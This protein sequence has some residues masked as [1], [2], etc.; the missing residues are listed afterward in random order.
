MRSASEND[1]PTPSST[2]PSINWPDEEY[3]QRSSN[4]LHH[5]E[6]QTG[7]SV[8]RKRKEYLVLTDTHI[9]RFKSQQ[10]ASET[11]NIIPPMKAPIKRHSYNLST[12]SA[13]D[14]LSS[15]EPFEERA[16]G[17]PL[18]NVVAVY[19]LDDG[20]PCFALQIDCLNERTN[21][22]SSVLLQFSEPDERDT[23]LYAI[24]QAAHEGTLIDGEP[25]SQFNTALV[26]RSV[27]RDGDYQPD[28]F[29]IYK[30][31]QRLS[32][33]VGDRSSSEDLTKSG[34]T[35]CFLVIG[36]YKI[37]IIPLYK[38]QNSSSS[39][40]LGSLATHESFGILAITCLR[41]CPSDDNFEITYRL[42]FQRSKVL[43]LA[44]VSSSDFV[45][46]FRFAEDVLRPE[47]E[48]RPYQFIV[49]KTFEESVH[50]LT[51]SAA[52]APETFERTLAGYCKAYGVSVGDISYQFSYPYE[53]A[54]CF[55]LLPPPGNSR[56]DYSSLELLAVLRALRYHESFISL[57]FANVSLDNLGG[58]RDHHGNEHI[59]SKTK[60]GSVIEVDTQ[61]LTRARLLVQ[62]IRALAITN[63]R[64]RRVDFSFCISRIPPDSF[65]ERRHSDPGCGIA[66]ALYLLFQHQM[67]NIDWIILNGIRMGE[68][69]MGYLIESASNPRCHFRALELSDCGISD[70]DFAQLFGALRNAHSSTLEAINLSKNPLRLDPYTFGA[71]VESFENLR[72]LCLA[73]LV[74]ESSPSPL[75]DPH[76]LRSWRLE[77]LH[78][79]GTTINSA[80]VE[81]I[82]IYLA[83]TQS[84]LLREL[85][86]DSTRISGRDIA[87]LLS[88]MTTEPGKGREI[89]LDVSRNRFET[90]FHELV[91]AVRR[92]YAPAYLT[93]RYMEFEE[94]SYFRR[95]IDAF[96]GNTTITHLDISRPSLPGSASEETIDSLEALLSR[97]IV[98]ESLDISGEDAKLEA[99]HL[100]PGLNR[101]LVGLK[102]N[103]SLRTLCVHFQRLGHR[104]ADTIAD[105]I[106]HNT[107]LQQLYCD[108][109]E[110]P[111]S[112]FT[113]IVNALEENT[114]LLVL[115]TMD[116]SREEGIK[117]TIKEATEVQGVG[118][119]QPEQQSSSMRTRIVSRVV[120]PKPRRP[121]NA[122]PI[123]LTQQDIQAAVGLL[124]HGWDFQVSRLQQYL[125]RNY[126]ITNG[127][128]LED[129][130]PDQ[131]Y[132]NDVIE[133]IQ[134]SAMAANVTE[135]LEKVKTD[136]TPRVEKQLNFDGATMN[137][138]DGPPSLMD[139][140]EMVL[141]KSPSIGSRADDLRLVLPKKVREKRDSKDDSQH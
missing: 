137:L 91:S 120:S 98:L 50:G 86:L 134:V 92:G 114:T 85:R 119:P 75:L 79:S 3:V 83:S 28:A 45:R 37:H 99:I 132:T 126:R 59:C 8:F 74:L 14:V 108:N 29:T 65:D 57:S 4:V 68:T 47:W 46:Q 127:L 104:G 12:G 102:Q 61:E 9:M 77:E 7:A 129:I 24:R 16:V 118:S 63:Q 80:T 73:N 70:R 139:E 112:G 89:H 54:P 43:Y 49:P 140:I 40:S 94:E 138:P 103:N 18:R 87:T 93:I 95:L 60:R 128:P 100:G 56:T 123:T 88:C 5:G 117:Q 106:R 90:G 96:A 109:N 44:S 26:A 110:I 19:V 38:F 69:D 135:L 52:M 72:K 116:E 55:E 32:P 36:P 97:N 10:K 124:H 62:E 27:E 82:G 51:P 81:S 53:D 67:T 141:E 33:K 13:N 136:S 115:P 101:A 78:L 31:V 76:I 41:L 39:P 42:P 84:K 1:V 23:W 130:I 34:S 64:L 22:A 122:L 133:D 35:V 121:S 15:L 125:E 107:S 2:T 21:Q 58:I 25:I 131:G 30:V 17:T 71:Q 11:F 66:E 6:A 111:L 20:R 48:T 105:I 113:N